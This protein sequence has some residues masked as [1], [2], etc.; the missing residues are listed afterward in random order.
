VEKKRGLVIYK[1]HEITRNI[2]FI[3]M[4]QQHCLNME[5]HLE[6]M[7]YEQLC[8]HLSNPKYLVGPLIDDELHYHFVINRSAT[9]W[10]NE[11]LELAGIRCFNTAYVARIANDK[12]LSHAVL[13]NIGIPM[14]SSTAVHKHFFLN[15]NKISK[16]RM[17]IK[18]P[19]GKG[20]TGVK[21]ADD[22]EEIHELVTSL[23]DNLL[24][25]PVGGQKGKDLRVYIVG[26]QIIGAILRESA[27]DFRA[28][29]SMGGS[30]RFYELNQSE[31]RLIS[32]ITDAI[33]LDFV[34]ID[35]LID[36]DGNLLFNEMEDAVGCRSLYIHSAID[37][38]EIFVAYIAKELEKEDTRKA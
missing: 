19:L 3:N 4:L 33:H 23:N 36:N 28:N 24:V 15:D 38:A 8:I 10:L 21:L 12:R 29:V 20:G 31:K 1:Q 26:N 25:Q 2:K 11:V 7:A 13:S 32:F 27:T 6:V 9:P 17:I 35:F 16:E 30:A 5:L 14:L 18:D 22:S 37:I 34:G